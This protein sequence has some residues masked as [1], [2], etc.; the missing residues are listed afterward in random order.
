MELIIHILVLGVVATVAIDLWAALSHKLLGTPTTN[1][2]MVGRW[3]GHVPR[4]VFVH[5]P[6]SA[7]APVKHELALGWVFHYLIG[8]A[9]ALLYTAIVILAL[10]N[11]PTLLSGW[12]F[13]LV[14]VVS[15]WF[16][17][18]PGLGLGV[19]ASKAPRPNVVRL[20]NLVIHSVF[21]LALYFAWLATNGLIA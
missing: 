11:E 2:S 6:I 19:C 16:I 9:Y 3:L 5:D 18:Q 15:P 1:W 17:L 10:G 7:A 12:V 8:I 4:G 14:T 20:Q 13:G 21:G